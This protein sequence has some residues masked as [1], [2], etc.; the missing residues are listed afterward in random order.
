MQRLQI[1]H[2]VAVGALP[3]EP[4]RSSGVVSSKLDARY[5]RSAYLT[6]L[7]G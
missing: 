7:M 3:P 1:L 5:A 2:H 4:L 6:T